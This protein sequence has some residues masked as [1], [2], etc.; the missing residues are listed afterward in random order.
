MLKL[1]L[2]RLVVTVTCI[3]AQCPVMYRY[4]SKII[5][6]CFIRYAPE[7]NRTSI[8][9]KSRFARTSKPL[10]A[11]LLAP[12]LFRRLALSVESRKEINMIISLGYGATSNRTGILHAARYI[13]FCET[14]SA[15]SC[16]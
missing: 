1:A 9:Q 8:V 12:L 11:S 5:L 7:H 6:W 3:E 13:T 2:P 16:E 14:R 4:V 10:R 15:V